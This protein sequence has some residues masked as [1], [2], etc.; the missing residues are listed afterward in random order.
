MPD[1]PDSPDSPQDDSYTDE[2]SFGIDA[3]AIWAIPLDN[4]HLRVYLNE[5]DCLT[6]SREAVQ[7]LV[8]VLA[9]FDALQIWSTE[10]V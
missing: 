10:S 4:D 2:I 9:P 3:Q 8:K 5:D 1:S 7:L 6:L